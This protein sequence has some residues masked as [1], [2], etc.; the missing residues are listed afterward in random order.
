MES[1]VEGSLRAGCIAYELVGT[2]SRWL[3]SRHDARAGRPRLHFRALALGYVAFEARGARAGF[4]GG[5][6]T[7]SELSS[8]ASR[9]GEWQSRFGWC[10]RLR[11]GEP[12]VRRVICVLCVVLA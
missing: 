3:G 6:D 1:G 2:A 7:L 12:F 8:A 9:A 10:S 4:A 5:F 11:K